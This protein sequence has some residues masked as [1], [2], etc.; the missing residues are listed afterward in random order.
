MGPD[1]VGER[2]LVALSITPFSYQEE[3][4]DEHY[5]EEQV[6]FDQISRENGAHH[7]ERV[8]HV[9]TVVETVPPSIV[10]DSLPHVGNREYCDQRNHQRDCQQYGQTKIVDP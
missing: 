2:D 10:A 7:A 9:E 4:W 5:L 8:E 1:E 6:E 3:G